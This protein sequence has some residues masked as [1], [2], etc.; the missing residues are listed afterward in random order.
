MPVV[1]ERRD[2]SHWSR[3]GSEV[4][5]WPCQFKALDNR[6]FPGPDS[7]FNL[8]FELL[9]TTFEVAES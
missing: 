2:L 5:K 6:P 3:A 7:D 9:L 1:E 8:H 4:P